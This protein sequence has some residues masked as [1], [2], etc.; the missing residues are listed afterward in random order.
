MADDREL[1]ILVKAK[2]LASSTLDSVKKSVTG[3]SDKAKEGMNIVA[4]AALG[5]GVAV[6]AGAYKTIQAFNE[7]ERA[8]L[9][10]EN[11]FK[12]MPALAGQT[13]DSIYALAKALQAKTA[14][15]DDSI[16]KGAALLGTFPATK[17]QI[18]GLLP[19]IVD[20]SRKFGV[21]MASASLQV[22]KA[23]MGQVA[24]LQRNG[25]T[26]DENLYKTDKY[27]AIVEAL[28]T[29]VGGFA[30]SEAKTF[31]GQLIQWKNRISDL[32]ETIGEW[33]TNKL[34]PG[35]ETLTKWTE[36][37]KKLVDGTTKLN[38][39]VKTIL[40]TIGT[41]IATVLGATLGIKALMMAIGAAGAV[42][43]F[44]TSPIGLVVL[45]LGILAAILRY[46][47]VDLETLKNRFL[48]LYSHI[49]GFLNPVLE[50]LKNAFMGLVNA[51]MTHLWPALQ[52]LWNAMQPLMPIFK[53]LAAI[54]AG[55]V[56]AAIAILVLALR[57]IVEVLT[58]VI[59]AIAAFT[60]WVVA[61]W[62]EHA[63]EIKAIWEGIVRYFRGVWEVITGIFDA[64]WT[65]IR[66]IFKA[67]WQAF[68]GDWTGAWETLKEGTRRILEDYKKIF[69][70]AIEAIKG[71]FQGIKEAFK[72]SINWVI[73][74]INRLGEFEIH[75]P[76]TKI[77]YKI[78]IPNI[79]KLAEGGIITKPTLALVGERGPEAVVPL[80][81][82]ISP[83]VNI[84]FYGSISVAS[85][86]D[87]DRLAKRLG[88]QM[89]LANMGVY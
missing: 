59:N 70:G 10:L 54:L 36:E 67:F 26:I 84:H 24:A 61:K 2:D 28:Q 75:I 41:F 85:D 42:F 37:I 79:P 63:I 7:S 19:L 74:G 6:A 55:V 35:L 66:T 87:V 20:Y 89:E 14:A 78:D 8:S 56:V 40:E 23:M 32:S 31:Q 51:V 29:Q 71:M 5:M 22:G 52:N 80:S 62:N 38:P 45:A 17:E 15:E 76:F 48:E 49:S 21:D 34:K 82:T 16:V 30:E 4:G 18:E 13:T 33:I 69:H 9:M 81:K 58:V 44:F 47:H 46:F 65:A 77:R 25:V 12:S 88:R 1:N 57:A 83:V 3:M 43:A 27:R 73:D 64:V 72:A 11:T 68:N 86:Y 50:F 60:N 39:Q 53:V